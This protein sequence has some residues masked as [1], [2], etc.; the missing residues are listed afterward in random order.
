MPTEETKESPE[1]PHEVTNEISTTPNDERD[2]DASD[3]QAQVIASLRSQVTD[4]FSQVTQLNSKLVASYDRV[5]NLEDQLHDTSASLRNAS[6]TISSLELERSHHLAA[7]NTGLL[8]EKAHVTTELNRLMERATEEAAQR[9]Q[10]ESARHDIEKDL[11]DLSATLFDQANTMVAEARLDQARS[12]RKV[13]EAEEALKSAEEAVKVMQTHMQALEADKERAEREAQEIRISMGKGK[14]IERED[15][16]VNEVPKVR[17]II[18]HAPY[19]EFIAFVAHLRTLRSSQSVLPAISSLLNQPFISRL[20][21]EDSEP[22]LRLDLAPSLNWLSRRSVLSAIHTGMLIIEPVSFSY[23]IQEL[24]S[25][26]QS[27]A[28]VSCALCGAPIVRFSSATALEKPPSHPLAAL[29]RSHNVNGHS[30]FKYPLALSSAQS[31]DPS[32]Y[33]P[34]AECEHPEQVYVFRLSAANPSQPPPM[35]VPTHTSSLSTSAASTS[36][37]SRPPIHPTTSSRVLPAQ[38]QNSPYPLC[39]S[40]YCLLRLRSTCSLWAFVRTGIVERV[41]E[42]QPQPQNSSPVDKPS[43]NGHGSDMPKRS[44]TPASITRPTSGNTS[45]SATE[46]PPVPPRRRRLWEMAS[47]LGERAVGWGKEGGENTKEKAKVEDG[48]KQLPNPP[49][50]HP[51]ASDSQAEAPQSQVPPLVPKRSGSRDHI[52]NDKSVETTQNGTTDSTEPSTVTDSGGP[53]SGTGSGD[54]YQTADEIASV[55]PSPTRDTSP[56]VEAEHADPAVSHDPPISSEAPALSQTPTSPVPRVTSPIPRPRSR[57]TSPA[58]PPSRV[59]SP[60]PQLP[61]SPIALSR[62]RAGSPAPV[63]ARTASPATPSRTGSPASP[64]GAPPLPR[65]AA[66]RRAIP[67]P[68]ASTAASEPSKD[69]RVSL[70]APEQIR[71]QE[72]PSKSDDG[73]KEND[74]AGPDITPV[75]AGDEVASVPVAATPGDDPSDETAERTAAAPS[76][77]EAP[78]P[79]DLQ[80]NTP[81]RT[82]TDSVQRSIETTS[83]KRSSSTDVSGFASDATWEERTWKEVA[84]LRDEMFWARIGGVRTT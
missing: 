10:A 14:W 59:G 7:L 21:T 6:I 46:K 32:V 75:N 58:S 15:H 73:P 23:L 38:P 77:S 61:V 78:A 47:V 57:V 1:E 5:S 68:P 26:S 50:A 2:E 34:S 66:A 51:S 62:S 33:R 11:D 40:N 60:R 65:R 43:T 69:K 20:V 25:Q 80:A 35:L 83:T 44:S 84:R 49:P 24:H 27:S 56:N 30:W 53:E 42:E 18:T 19:A 37:L 8:V 29:A 4:L 74:A 9:G 39:T 81:D 45:P 76:T 16:R 70:L 52:W 48:G 54:A 64:H 28:A 71:A 17:F 12:E 72:E 31:R 22:T 79:V 63:I 3:A 82:S 13:R 67:P 55:P 41:W 36:I